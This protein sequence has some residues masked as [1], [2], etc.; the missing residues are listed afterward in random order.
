MLGVLNELKEMLSINWKKKKKKKLKKIK[1]STF[2]SE[3]A[4]VPIKSFFDVLFNSFSY[5]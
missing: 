1:L 5:F 3:H 2:Y 4:T